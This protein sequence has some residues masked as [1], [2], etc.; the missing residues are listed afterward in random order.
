M[1]NRSYSAKQSIDLLMS[2]ADG[3]S[4]SLPSPAALT[5]R[6]SRLL[7]KPFDHRDGNHIPPEPIPLGDQKHV[8]TAQ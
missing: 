8:T 4:P 3:S 7:T 2:T 5:I 6:A 1:I